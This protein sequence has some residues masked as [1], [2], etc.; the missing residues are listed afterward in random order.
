M[1]LEL[2]PRKEEVHMGFCHFIIVIV[3]II[4]IIETVP[5]SYTKPF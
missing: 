3:I 5:S 2:P 4:V 1:L